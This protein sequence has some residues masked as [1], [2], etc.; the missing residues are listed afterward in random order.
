MSVVKINVL[1]VP[2]GRGE[3]LE[4]RFS[5]RAGEV[6]KVDGF[7]SFELLRP[8]EGFDRYLVV[9][10]WR[11]EESFENWMNSQAFQK[12]HAQSQGEAARA[13]ASEGGGHPGV[14]AGGGPQGA[15]GGAPGGSGGGPAATGSELWHFDIVTS[16]TKA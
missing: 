16:A 5:A 12:G 10:R 7:E 14:P 15:G 9:T 6:E 4:Q 1:Q 2:E 11:D 3:V 8:T 13:E